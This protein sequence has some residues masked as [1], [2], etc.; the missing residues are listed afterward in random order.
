VA[1][2]RGLERRRLVV[3]PFH[4]VV[5]AGRSLDEAVGLIETVE[6]ACEIYLKAMAA[7]G[8]S[9]CLGESELRKVAQRF[10]VTPDPEILA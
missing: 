5:A 6:K 8:P 7:G 1:T 2:A 9:T 10:G 4:G 3:W